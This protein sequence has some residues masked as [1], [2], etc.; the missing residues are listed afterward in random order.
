MSFTRRYLPIVVFG[1]SMGIAVNT[2]IHP[3]FQGLT[4]ATAFLATEWGA[5]R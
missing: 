3:F 5:S 4:F 2:D 1:V